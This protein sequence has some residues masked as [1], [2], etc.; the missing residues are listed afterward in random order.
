MV[1]M[2]TGRAR[3]TRTIAG[4]LLAGALGLGA[5]ACEPLAAPGTGATTTTTAG[6]TTTQPAT[7]GGAT[8]TQP[9]TGSPTTTTIAA[10]S[11]AA[12]TTPGA[13][14]T[15]PTT[16]RPSTTTARPTTT[17][18]VPTTTTTTV[19]TTTTAPTTTSTSSLEVQAARAVFDATNAA[20]TQA[21]LP[22]LAWNE[23]L[24]RSG[25]EHN[26]AMAAA[27]Q[28]SHQLPGEP[29]FGQRISAQ[30]V[31]WTSIG[32]NVGVTSQRTVAGALSLHT[33]MINETPPD[34]GHRRN[35]LSTSFTQLGVSVYLDAAHG[36]LWLTEDY[37]RL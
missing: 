20:R 16:T 37:A 8:T 26:L 35:K 32:E 17:T 6:A 5:V 24:V 36:R 11:V 4:A 23:A 10:T 33:A 13:S 18:A 12:T 25:R 14:T 1:G 28:L 2:L 19:P 34:D 21:G 9:S 29:G 7:S 15:T 3:R 27:N 31:R 30:G 22:V